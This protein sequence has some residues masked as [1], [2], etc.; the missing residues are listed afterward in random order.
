[1]TLRVVV[2]DDQR[3][4]RDGLVMVLGLLKSIE[5][6]CSAEDGEQVMTLVEQ[7]EPDVVLMDLRM[8]RVDGVEATRRIKADILTCR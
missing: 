5:L 3:I 6:V 8:P 2:A 1:M 4:V 7:E